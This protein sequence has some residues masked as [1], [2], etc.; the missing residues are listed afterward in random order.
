MDRETFWSNA[1]Q[2]FGSINPARAR[3]VGDII[4]G[5]QS[6]SVLDLGCGNQ[7]VKSFLKLDRCKYIPADLVKRS[8]DC[9]VL[10]LEKEYLAGYFHTILSIGVVGYIRNRKLLYLRVARSC[11]YW[12][13]SVAG[14]ADLFSRHKLTKRSNSISEELFIHEALEYFNLCGR[15][16]CV[17]G[18]RV[19]VWTPKSLQ[20]RKQIRKLRMLDQ[21]L[22]D[23][24]TR[25]KGDWLRSH[26]QRRTEYIDGIT[27]ILDCNESCTLSSGMTSRRSSTIK[28]IE[29]I[30]ITMNDQITTDLGKARARL[31]AGDA[32]YIILT[33]G[34]SKR[35]VDCG[36]C[37]Q[38]ERFDLERYN[39]ELERHAMLKYTVLFIDLT[40]DCDIIT[41]F[42][43]S[44]ERLLA[45]EASSGDHAFS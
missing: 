33:I 10:D 6:A 18:C 15:S 25:T 16:T 43:R 14:A 21:S 30:E 31:D 44:P 8:D 27:S 17:T 1:G 39:E 2:L 35:G 11:E 37:Y 26:M 41:I 45:G 4:N 13:S 32:H 19:L 38:L 23:L 36:S 29:L 40:P 5:L 24:D 12:I 3:L 9:L 42:K 34:Y 28:A 7:A 22:S 20:D